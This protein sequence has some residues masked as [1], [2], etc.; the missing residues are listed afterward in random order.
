MLVRMETA[1]TIMGWVAIAILAWF[2]F[3]FFRNF[4]RDRQKPG[5]RTDKVGKE[6][7]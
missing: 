4:V 1:L 2:V 3:S 7:Y 5:A 6:M